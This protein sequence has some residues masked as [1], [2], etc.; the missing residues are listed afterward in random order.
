MVRENKVEA[1][2]N[3]EDLFKNANA[4]VMA[5]YR[6][7]SV[8]QQTK[9]RREL[10]KAG[11][12]FNVVKMTLAKRAAENIGLESLS[13]HFTGPTGITVIESDPVEAAKVLKNFAKDNEAFVVKGGLMNS[14]PL[15]VDQIN[16][17][18]NIEPR[19]VLLAKIAGGFNAPL[20]KLAMGTKAIINKVGYA[21]SALL[22]KK[23]NGIE[24]SE[25]DSKED[26]SA[27][28]EVNK[29]EE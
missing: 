4:L 22:E 14:E 1:V 13:E 8:S 6:G 15:T 12:S 11:A 9:L 29:E 26:I 3:L 23:D 5:E 19:D 20:V 21:F 7:L 24:V 25:A 10:K 27:S 2:K 17:L 16:V 28:E 18:A